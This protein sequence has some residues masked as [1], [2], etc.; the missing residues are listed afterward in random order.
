MSVA[1]LITAH[2]SLITLS[3]FPQLHVPVGQIEEMFPAIVMV[4]TDVHLHKRPPLRP[5]RFANQVHARFAGRPVRLMR[6]TRNTRTDNILPRRRPAA[7][8]RDY[9]IEIQ[10]AAFET[11]AAILASILVTLEN[12]VA[13]ELDLFLRQAIEQQQQ[14]YARHPDPEGDRVNALRMR[15]LLRKI[16]PLVEIVRLERSIII[17]QNHLRAA[18]E[19]QRKRP[20]SCAN[21]H[22]LPEPV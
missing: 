16:V 4:E 6:I 20:A 3:S 22:C 12:V 9:V 1:Q 15:L 19:Q 2:W 5:L 10:I 11:V 7:V 21:I 17:V 14:N 18:F 13:S 8:A